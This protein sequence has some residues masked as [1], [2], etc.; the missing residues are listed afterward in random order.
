[1]FSVSRCMGMGAT[2]ALGSD[3]F[4]FIP[5]GVQACAPG[6]FCALQWLRHSQAAIEDVDDR[7]P[8]ARHGAVLAIGFAI[9]WINLTSNH[10][11]P[12]IEKDSTKDDKGSTV[13]SQQDADSTA[14]PPGATATTSAGASTE[15]RR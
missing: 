5:I 13:V 4:S 2:G 12:E 10:F 7:A 6:S 1:M 14:R 11:R 15:V 8:R 9:E 3:L